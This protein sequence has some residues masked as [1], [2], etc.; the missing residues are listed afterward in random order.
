MP[1]PRAALWLHQLGQ[2]RTR[3]P[4]DFHTACVAALLLPGQHLTEERSS[5]HAQEQG[6]QGRMSLPCYAVNALWVKTQDRRKEQAGALSHIPPEGSHPRGKPKVPPLPPTTG[7]PSQP[8]ETSLNL[9][10]YDCV[11]VCMCT[12]ICMRAFGRVQL[13]HLKNDKITLRFLA[14]HQW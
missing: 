9:P 10:T 14:T 13:I 8:L 5:P 11:Q 6:S 1:H 12:C 7:L 2:P 3:I 4:G